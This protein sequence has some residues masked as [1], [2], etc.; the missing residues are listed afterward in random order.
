MQLFVRYGSI[1]TIKQNKKHFVIIS[2]N[3][4]HLCTCMLLV[5]KGL[6]C[7]HFFSVMTNSDEAMF[8][9]R[10]I[11]DQWYNEKAKKNLQLQFVK[12]A[13]QIVLT[14]HSSYTSIF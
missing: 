10:L 9:I 7:R 13:Q 1:K 6:V 14:Q 3:A 5:S 2:D 11:P 4:N 8:H 12:N